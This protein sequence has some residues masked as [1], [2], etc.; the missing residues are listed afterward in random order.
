MTINDLFISSI[1]GKCT[2][3]SIAVTFKNGSTADY[4]TDIFS[5]LVSDPAT[6][7]IISNETGEVYYT[8]AEN[9]IAYPESYR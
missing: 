5:L 2:A 4:S 7:E 3:E 6:A 9:Y 8:A 1:C